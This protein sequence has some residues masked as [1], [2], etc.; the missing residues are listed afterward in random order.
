[1]YEASLAFVEILLVVLGLYLLHWW[2][3]K[4]ASETE[5]KLHS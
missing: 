5:G 1:M 4:E 3:N 2:T